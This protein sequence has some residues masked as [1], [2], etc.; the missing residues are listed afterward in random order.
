[1]PFISPVCRALRRLPRHRAAVTA[2]VFYCMALPS[3]AVPLAPVN[4]VNVGLKPATREQVRAIGQALLLSH[5]KIQPDQDAVA[6][7]HQIDAVHDALAALTTPV[8]PSIVAVKTD[9]INA[10]AD[11][12]SSAKAPHIKRLRLAVAQLRDQSHALRNKRNGI[13]TAH[14]T[15]TTATNFIQTHAPVISQFVAGW[16]GSSATPATAKTHPVITSASDT[17]LDRFDRLDA[18][19]TA[20][21]ALPP[22]QRQARLMVLSQ[23]FSFS[24][25]AASQ[26]NQRIPDA[27]DTPTLISRFSGS[28]QSH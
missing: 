12:W 6:L 13:S 11:A 28:T 9:S 8:A 14:S 26:Q 10:S 25:M 16:Q 21:L 3:Y 2:T 24:R 15:M 7:H 1:M 17:A 19:I 5:R 18:D 22:A 20:A 23:E 4:D 27:Q